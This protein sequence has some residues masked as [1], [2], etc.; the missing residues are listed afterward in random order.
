MKSIE[1]KSVYK[2]YH[3]REY[4]FSAKDFFW[5]LENISF[6]VKKGESLGI[7]GPNGA[8]KTTIGRLI[9]GITYATQ[10]SVCTKGKVVP[11]IRMEGAM[12]YLLTARENIELISAA[13]GAR[14]KL[15][16]QIFDKIVEFSQIESYLDMLSCKLSHG[17][18]SR[19]SFSIAI[20]VPSDIILIDEVLAVG[21]QN[22]QMK[23]YRK[24]Q[25]MKE[26]NK[27]IIFISHNLEKVKEVCDKIIW[28]DKG[29]L[30]EEGTP[31]EVISKYVSVS[32]L[33]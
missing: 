10:G 9:S 27:T 7:I 5:A 31:K 15:R 11:L 23:C 22:F 16:K 17:M 12:N 8:G 6:S 26:S 3:K 30:V 2:K 20:N 18:V 4:F 21:D 14:G 33:S 28:I 29:Q 13:Y 32:D 24:I 1:L 19:I 25:E